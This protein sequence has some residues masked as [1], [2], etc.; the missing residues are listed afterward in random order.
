MPLEKIPSLLRAMDVMIVPSRDEVVMR[1][2]FCLA[3]VQG[4]LTGLPLLVSNLPILKEKVEA[5]GGLV[6][7]SVEA[8]RDALVKLQED[9]E[10]LQKLAGEARAVALD[11]FIWNMDEFV[12]RFL[13]PEG[14]S[15]S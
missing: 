10:L 14:D 3:A 4:M 12:Q 7:D 6:F 2:T 5:G 13:F 9:R 8:L 11:R 15:V 1:E